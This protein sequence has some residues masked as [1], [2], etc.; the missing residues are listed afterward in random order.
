MRYVCALLTLALRDNTF[1]GV[2]IA[3][4][5]AQPSR[6]HTHNVFSLQDSKL[7]LD[8]A[9]EHT[10]PAPLLSMLMRGAGAAALSDG[11]QQVPLV[12]AAEMRVFESLSPLLDPNPRRLKRILSV[13]ALV[14]EV[15]KRVPL[16]DVGLTACVTV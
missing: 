7:P 1:Y 13:Y 15:S 2:S 3:S 5:L 9:L 14:T 16:S 11:T 8:L 6:T 10:Y 12:S 4:S